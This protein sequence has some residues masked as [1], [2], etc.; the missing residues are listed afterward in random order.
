MKVNWEKVCSWH[1]NKFSKN[2]IKN[3]AAYQI[4]LLLLKKIFFFC[5]SSIISYLVFVKL[6]LMGLMG[7]WDLEAAVPEAQIMNQKTFYCRRL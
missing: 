3:D 5:F 7:S 6:V 2:S 4:L 1:I